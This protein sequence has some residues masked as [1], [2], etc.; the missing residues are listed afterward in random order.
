M[1]CRGCSA[2]TPIAG[3]DCTERNHLTKN[4]IYPDYVFSVLHH[5]RSASASMSLCRDCRRL[6]QCLMT[7]GTHGIFQC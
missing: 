2:F 3:A 5:R 1:C 4:H 6:K 7:P